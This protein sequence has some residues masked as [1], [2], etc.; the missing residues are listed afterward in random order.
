MLLLLLNLLNFKCEAL[1]HVPG[2]CNISEFEQYYNPY[3]RAISYILVGLIPLS[4]L[5]LVLKWS[6]VKEIAIYKEISK[7]LT[8]TS[9]FKIIKSP[10]MC[11]QISTLLHHIM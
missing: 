3:I 8:S 1:G 5:N 2:K 10:M 4:V 11:D 7:V 9:L 6:S